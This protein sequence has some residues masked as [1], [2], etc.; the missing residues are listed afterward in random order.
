MIEA[1][2]ARQWDRA[3]ARTDA[4]P[5]SE[6]LIRRAVNAKAHTPASMSADARPVGAGS[7][8]P[9]SARPSPVVRQPEASRR[10]RRRGKSGRRGSRR[11]FPSR[12]A[13][14]V[15]GPGGGGRRLLVHQL[16]PRGRAARHGVP[17]RSPPVQRR[18]EPGARRGD[19]RREPAAL[20]R[21]VPDARARRATSH[22]PSLRPSGYVVA[23]CALAVVPP[24]ARATPPPLRAA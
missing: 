11:A 12:V 8:H 16:V 3:L 7:A 2:Q 19:R 5:M 18:D 21:G 14:A 15:P 9:S 24:A 6:P 20:R 4:C 13:P 10:P 23:S 22:C 17:V 1:C